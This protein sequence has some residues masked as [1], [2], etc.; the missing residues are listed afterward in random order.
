MCINHK[1]NTN[2]N[3]HA[4][5]LIPT[6]STMQSLLNVCYDYGSDNDILFIPVNFVCTSDKTKAYTIYIVIYLLCHCYS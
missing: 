6:A 1:L 5:M 4:C 2:D 3:M